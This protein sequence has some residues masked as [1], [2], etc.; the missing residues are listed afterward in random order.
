[1]GGVGGS[2]GLTGPVEKRPAPLVDRQAAAKHPD[3]EPLSSHSYQEAAAR[4]REMEDRLAELERAV[5]AASGA[6]GWSDTVR[7]K[8][9]DLHQALA[10]HILAVEAPDGLLADI[11]ETAPR[12]ANAVQAMRDAHGTLAAR[13][14]TLIDDSASVPAVE[15]R[16]DV[17]DLF[18]QMM[19]HRQRGSDL[20]YEAFTRDIGGLDS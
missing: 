11:V 4:R 16:E 7:H 5:A 2:L 9:G 6:T 3:M 8:L 19:L 1:M 10:H 14:Q 17:V 12:L 20:V 18:H 15:L 13:I